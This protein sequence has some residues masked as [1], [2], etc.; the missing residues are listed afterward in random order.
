MVVLKVSN[1]TITFDNKNTV[2]R[3]VNFELNKNETLAIV[4]ESG[5]GK[6]VTSKAIMGLLPASIASI[7]GNVYFEG[8]DL[9]KLS[10]S[11]MNRIRGKD[12]AMILQ[13]PFSSLNPVLKIG[14]QITDMLHSHNRLSNREAN[15]IAIDLLRK[16]NIPEAERR[17]SQYPHQFSG[18]MCQRVLIAIV[19]SSN[20]QVLIADEPTTALDVTVQAQIIKLIK[21]LQ[22]LYGLSILFITHNL[23][24]VAEVADKVLVMYAGQVV[25]YGSIFDIFDHPIHP[26]TKGLL[27]SLPSKSKEY[28]LLSTIPGDVKDAPMKA[29]SFEPRCGEAIKECKTV[30]PSLSFLEGRQVRCLRASNSGVR[31]NALSN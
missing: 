24:L 10:R 23:G 4:G 1:L 29:C 22:A 9:L 3:D 13:E 31:N 30:M 26:Y 14:Q 15:K 11:Q 25:E 7:S 6:S 16:V 21:D 28:G 18:G 5:C 8:K 19:L 2:V 20:P 27:A 17:F 12:I